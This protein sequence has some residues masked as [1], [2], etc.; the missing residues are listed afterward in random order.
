[1]AYTHIGHNCELGSGIVL[2]NSVQV[3]GHVKVEDKAIIGGCLG[4]HQFVHIGYLAMIGGMTRVD[5]DVPPFCLAE[6]HPGRLRGLNR[7]GI[8]RSG[9]ME[10]KDFDI[11]LLQSTWNL[12]FKSNNVMS[13]ALDIAIQGK[14]DLSS[15]KL[16][17]FLKDSILK[18]RRGPMPLQN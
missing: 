15:R 12:L 3:A 18:E 8:K 9:L 7:I 5:R 14:L 6:G 13:N 4:I 11:K 1:M 10:N 16:C 17:D 2:S